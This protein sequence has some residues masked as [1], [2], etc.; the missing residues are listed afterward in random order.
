MK[1]TVS[2]SGGQLLVVVGELQ[3][4]LEVGDR[5]QTAHQERRADVVAEGD[6]QAV[7]RRDLDPD[8]QVRLAVEDRADD[9]DPVLRG[10]QRGLA[11]IAEHRDR[12]GGRRRA[13]RAG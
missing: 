7:E 8:R 4:G 13:M 12:R 3:L 11:G 5:T 6:G 9:G 2:T 1:N 10:Q